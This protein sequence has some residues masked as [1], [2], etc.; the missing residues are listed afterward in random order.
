ML[1]DT[2][3]YKIFWQD[4]SE[5]YSTSVLQPVSAWNLIGAMLSQVQLSRGVYEVIPLPEDDPRAEAFRA[6]KRH[7][8][9][10][11][12]PDPADVANLASLEGLVPETE[13]EE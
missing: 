2:R 10:V 3:R 9:T 11:L 5:L 6:L 1:T 4:G 8:P 13:D 12:G 7:V